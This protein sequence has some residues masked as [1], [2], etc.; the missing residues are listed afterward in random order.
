V[1]YALRTLKPLVAALAMATL[2]CVAAAQDEAKPPAK[3]SYYT[4]VRPIL[5]AH[6][7]GCHQPAKPGGG[8][9]MTSFE[10]LIAGGESKVAAVVPQKP[11]ESHLIEQIT[12]DGGKALMPKDKPPLSPAELEIVSKWV[13]EGAVDDTPANARARYDQDHLPAYRR[14]P[15]IGAM[16]FSPDGTLVAIGG[17]HEVLVWKADGSAPVARLVGLSERI[18]S[19]R[20]SPDGTRLAVTGGLPGRMGEVQVWNVAKWKLALSVPVTFDTVYGASWSPDGSKIALGGADNG[21]RAI[22]AKTGAQVLFMG[23]H[24]DWALDTTFSADGSH[25]ISVGRDMAAK[26]T[27]VA[28]QRFVDNITSITPGALKGGLAAV[29]R[30]PTRD[31]ILIGG[32][33]GIPR[34]YRVFRQTVRVIGDD[35]NLIR[36]F[37]PMR[38]R[39]TSVAVSGDG[40]RIAAGS[41]LDNAGEVH[42]YSYE[43]DTGLPDPIKAIMSKVASTRSP[44]EAA[45]LQKY[46]KD[47]VKLVSRLDLPRAAVYAVAFSPDGKSLAAAGSDGLVRLVNPETGTIVKEFAPAPVSQQESLGERVAASV[48]AKSEEPVETET[49]PKGAKVVSLTTQPE[50]VKLTNRFAYAQVLVAAQLESGDLVDVTRMV[51]AKPAAHLVEVGRSGVVRPVADGQAAL[52]YS[53]EGLKVEIPVTV[54][55]MGDSLKVDFVHDVNPVM[56]RMGCNQ[57]TCHGS[58]QGKNGFK[59]SLRGYDPIFDVRALTDDQAARRVNLASPDDSLML[60]KPTG[61]VPHVGGQV[62]VPGEPYYEI[63][64]RWIADGAVLKP[65]TPR[66]A[67]IELSPVNPVIQQVGLKQQIRVLATYTDGEVRDVTREAFVETGNMEVVSANRSGLMT[68]LRRGEAPLLARFEGAYAATTLTVMGD[69]TGFAWEPPP[70]YGK[71]DEL[72]AAKWRTMK[73]KPSGLSTDAEFLRRV[74]LDLT[75]LPPKADDVRAFLSDGRDSRLKR[76][77]LV[78][79]LIGSK[80]YVEYW[81]NKWADLLQ[82]NRK[83]LGVEGSVAFRKWIRDQVE[84]NV[85]YDQF[86]RSL[87]TS[88]GSNRE[89]PEA[90]YYKILRDPTTIMENTTQLFL[91]VRFN[92]NKCHDHPFEKWTQDQY[93]QTSAF[94]A[95]VGLKPDPAAGGKTIGGTN[96][97]APKPLYEQVW[98]MPEGEVIHDRTKK[99]APAVFP[100]ETP[101]PTSP[102]ATRRQE[103]AAWVTSK[104]NTYFARSYVN[105]LWGYLFGVGIIEPLDDI[106]A[107]NPATNPELLDYL[108]AEFVKSGFDARHVV[109]LICKSRTYQLS[110]NTN[111]WNDDDKINYSHASARRLPAEVLYDSVNRVTGAVSKFPGVPA[112]TRAAE[113]PDSEVELPSGFLTTFGRPARESACEC[114]RSSGLQLGPVMALVSGPTIS[115]AIGDPGNEVAK[116]VKLQADD[117][118]L[119]DELFMRVLNRPATPEE[120]ASC[121]EVL[122]EIDTDHVRLADALGKKETEIAL[123]RPQLERQR[124]AEITAATT[125]LAAHEAEI[126]P[127]VAAAEAQRVAK[128]AALDKDVKDYEGT[129]PAKVAEWEKTQTT[130]VRW[131]PLQPKELKAPKGTTLTAGPDGSIIAGGSNGNGVYEVVTETDLSDITGIRLEVLADDKLPAKGPGRANDGNF[132][133]TELEVATAPKADPKAA[134]PVKLQNA[135]A[136]FSQLNLPVAAAIDGDRT[137]QGT[138][139]GLYPA[140]GV[141]QWA[142]FEAATPVGTPGGTILTIKLNHFLAGNIYTIGRFRLSVTRVARPIGLGLPE[143]YRAILA[144]AP[145]IRTE[146]QRATL[147]SFHR[148]ID[149]EYRKRIDAANASRVPLPVDPRLQ[150]LRDR[151]A[152]VSKPLPIDPRLAQMRRDVEMSIKQAVE[153]RLTAAQDIAWALINSPAFLFNH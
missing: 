20:F 146:S 56:S 125:T 32:S 63:L 131:V 34:L 48:G 88:G 40:K 98:D 112:G 152:A 12:P 14:P 130:A 55:G 87:L 149:P 1:I 93:Y 97:E 38:G 16:D 43:F 17:F 37:E 153:R 57:G 68:S 96:V 115:D 7:L 119:V 134:K 138:G 111:E 120:I 126:A 60:L 39:V 84:K 73:I 66:V 15:V 90:S 108:T 13:G 74:H 86:V 42:V 102:N 30:H 21:V 114:E 94:F 92:C 35:S 11:A 6:C 51:E 113:L 10:R 78:D 151:L 124:E 103:L 148:A 19:V 2:P 83:F 107:G 109:R 3:V 150:E 133:L 117:A 25:L 121:I 65:D 91:G 50:A 53:L 99:V 75:G 89:H 147:L 136:S 70:T 81:T 118:K 110:V 4:Q 5:Q 127:K 105:R 106:R 62:M 123:K 27:E 28:T 52:T 9:V 85:P 95:R 101:H 71:I 140:T 144:T 76:D 100:F 31:E 128:T 47:G 49:L 69:R 41:S 79:K 58:A 45:A 82:V 61:A 24:N 36:E 77:E 72:V 22:D 142:T 122:S 18:E 129:L 46:I 8:Y 80:E 44:D 137:N 139:W 104:D 116:L 64:R 23:S 59:L 132:V 29:A 33:D 145:E 54:S 135:L 26:L 141:T 143:D 67:K